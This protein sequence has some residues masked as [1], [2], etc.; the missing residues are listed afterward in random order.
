MYPSIPTFFRQWVSAQIM[1]S[2]RINGCLWQTPFW[3]SS[4]IAYQTKSAA[5]VACTFA[6]RVLSG[7]LADCHCRCLTTGTAKHHG[8]IVGRGNPA[9][10]L[11]SADSS[12]AMLPP[13][14]SSR[15]V[16]TYK[17]LLL[18]PGFRV[19]PRT[20]S[21]PFSSLALYFFIRFQDN[22]VR[23]AFIGCTP[24]RIIWSAS[25]SGFVHT[26]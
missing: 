13:H 26:R 14:S 23:H 22:L 11:R 3:M 9:N 2:Q 19:L 24:R 6:T 4:S 8:V 1:S 7:C 21:P 15:A 25:P 16:S 10:L 12:P 18:Y 20:R 5:L 17:I